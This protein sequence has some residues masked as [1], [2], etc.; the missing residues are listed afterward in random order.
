MRLLDTRIQ[1]S[2][3]REEAASP[4]PAS[5]QPLIESPIK[6]AKPFSVTPLL[7]GWLTPK[8]SDPEE[9]LTLPTS[10]FPP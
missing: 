8:C 1:E 7:P 2:E 10:H 3:A 9:V 5:T 6:L 4:C